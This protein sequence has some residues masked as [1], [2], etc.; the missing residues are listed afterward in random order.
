MQAM[1]VFNPKSQTTETGVLYVRMSAEDKRRVV[2][3]AHQSRVS[4][5]A[6]CVQA[7]LFAL[8]HLPDAAGHSAKALHDRSK[9]G[10]QEREG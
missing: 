4:T 7:I 6:L 10:G 1:Q 2:A 3:A 5:N 8:D 9:G